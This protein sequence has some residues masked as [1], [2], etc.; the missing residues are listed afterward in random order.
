MKVIGLV[1]PIGSGCSY[2]AE[3]IR[4]NFNY[5]YLSLSSI[6]KDRFSKERPGVTSTR[7]LLQD[8]GDNIRMTEGCDSLAKTICGIIK[9]DESKNYVIDSIRNP[10]EVDCFRETFSD[11]F[12][13]G[14][15]AD[16]NIRWDRVKK[17]YDDDEREFNKDDKRDSGEK[18][19]YGQQV[20]K[21]FKTSDIVILNNENIINGSKNDTDFSS[22]IDEK[23]AFISKTLSFR[24]TPMETYMS[25]A[26]AVSMRSSCSKRKVGAIIID[27]SGNVFSSGY[28]EVPITQPPC[29]SEYGKCY[30]DTLKKDFKTKLSDIIKDAKQFEETYD[31]FISTFKILDYCRALHAEENAIINVAKAGS[32]GLLHNATLYTT[33]YPCNLCANKIVQVGIKNIVYFEPYPMKESKAILEKGHTEQTPFEGVTYNGYFRLKEK[34]KNE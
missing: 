15:F 7:A 10:G 27:D 21:C 6:L 17:K 9:L 12:L 30:R 23:I 19:S 3:I 24:P 4:K 13:F 22:K 2:V 34:L 33:T 29:F 16:H 28:N 26:Y 11:F 20:T 14:V 1:G 25:M 31:E 8:F 5:E 18:I 32:S